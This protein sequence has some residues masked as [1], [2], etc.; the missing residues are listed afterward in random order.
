MLDSLDNDAGTVPLSLL[1][2]KLRQ[3]RH[4]KKGSVPAP[5]CNLDNKRYVAWLPLPTGITDHVRQLREVAQS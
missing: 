1:C 4:Q 2:H 3:L 5:D